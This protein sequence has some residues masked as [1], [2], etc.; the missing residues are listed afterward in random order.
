MPGT[1]PRDARGQA[2]SSPDP[3]IDGGRLLEDIRRFVAVPSVSADPARSSDV[4]RSAQLVAQAF[5][6]AGLAAS[7]EAAP[8]G[9]PA[10]LG[11]M[12]GPPDAPTVLLYAHHDVQPIGLPAEWASDPFVATQW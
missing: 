11:H 12:P 7:V 8:G 6:E 9:A 5:T 10:V 2:G 4:V 1:P 3:P